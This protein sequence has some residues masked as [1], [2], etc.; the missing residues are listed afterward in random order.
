MVKFT[1][2][3]HIERDKYDRPYN[4]YSWLGSMLTNRLGM[5]PAWYDRAKQA[6]TPQP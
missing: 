3:G 2:D 5:S 6:L 4:P 1:P